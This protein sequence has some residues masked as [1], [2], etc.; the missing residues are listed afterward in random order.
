MMMLH[1]AGMTADQ[2]RA[3][4]ACLQDNPQMR[5]AAEM[6]QL[7]TEF[8]DRAQPTFTDCYS[9]WFDLVQWLANTAPHRDPA[10]RFAYPDLWK[11]VTG[12]SSES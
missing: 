10:N 7:F 9:D 1:A 12:P 11:R 4:L 5:M 3:V 6:P 2:V 8:F